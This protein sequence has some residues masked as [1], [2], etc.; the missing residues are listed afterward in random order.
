MEFMELSW[1]EISKKALIHNL[2]AFRG[3]VGKD[4]VLAPAVKANAYGHGLIEC[5]RIFEKYGA[6][7]LCVNALFEARILREA[8]IKIPILIIGYTPLSDLKNLPNKTELTVYNLETIKTLGKLGKKVKVHLKIETGNY[9]QGI[10]LQDLPTFISLIKRYSHIQVVGIS[11]HFANLED[12][13]N[14]EYAL[15]QLKQFNKAVHLLENEGLAPR[16]R[17]CANTAATILLPEAYFNFVRT[18]IGNYGLWPSEKTELAAKRANINIELKPALT[19][20]TVVAQ[21]KE[22][23]KGSLIGYGCTYKMSKNGRIAVLPVGYYD[24]FVRLLSNRGHAIIRGKKAPVIGRVCM[25]MIMVD[26][27]HI[28]DAKL[29]DEAVLIGMQGKE[30]ITAEEIADLSQTINYEVTTRINERIPRILKK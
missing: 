10:M 14:Q 30:K 11:T 9:R 20:K 1:V 19:W 7:Y 5:A 16:F 28:P 17:H 3:L 15:Y 13:I 12:R 22:I 25:N 24:G 8:G 26:V 21:I 6:D 29:E 27:T 4:L 18:G 2:Q 23:K